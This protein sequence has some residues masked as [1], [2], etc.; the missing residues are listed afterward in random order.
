[1]KARTSEVVVPGRAANQGG[2]RRARGFGRGGLGRAYGRGREAGCRGRGG[3]GHG[4]GGHGGGFAD[5]GRGRGRRRGGGRGRGRGRGRGV[6]VGTFSEWNVAD[7]N[8]QPQ[9]FQPHREPGLHLPLDFHPENELSFFQL[10]F[11]AEIIMQLVTFTN[12][13][14]WMHILDIPSHS[15]QDGSWLETNPVEMSSFLALVLYFGL[16]RVQ[17]VEKYWGTSSLYNGL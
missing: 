14:A 5:R 12:T 2:R 8:P 15:L 6:A 11:T 7:V 1:M 3:G 17:D 13:Y 9:Q 16:I 10:F 4:R